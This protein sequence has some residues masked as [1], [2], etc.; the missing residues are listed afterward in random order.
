MW[1][2]RALSDIPAYAPFLSGL[3]G[4][5]SLVGYKERIS[6]D[7]QY[8]D[9][10]R[11][12]G[13][14]PSPALLS[15][16]NRSR[17]MLTWQSEAAIAIGEAFVDYETNA[18]VQTSWKRSIWVCHGHYPVR[19]DKWVAIAVKLTRSGL[20]CLMRWLQ[21]WPLIRLAPSKRWENRRALDATLSI[22]TSKK[23]E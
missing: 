19:N 21:N 6:W 13:A 20:I 9:T 15:A 5:D 17:A 7:Q 3:T 2:K 8:A 4:L 11:I 23:T 18:S 14:W 16:T 12:T 22:L 1:E 10:K